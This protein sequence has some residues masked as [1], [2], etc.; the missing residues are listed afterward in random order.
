MH[1]AS[2]IWIEAEHASVKKAAV[3]LLAAIRQ[4]TG[5]PL[6]FQ[7]LPLLSPTQRRLL[8]AYSSLDL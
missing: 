7:A 3:A 5:D 4:R 6:F 1:S 2:Q 8:D